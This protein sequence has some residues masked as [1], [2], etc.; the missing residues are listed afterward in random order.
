MNKLTTI[1]G[2]LAL[3]LAVVI[4]AVLL[5]RPEVRQEK[6]LGQ[7]PSGLPAPN[8][9]ATS[10][11]YEVGKVFVQI[12]STSSPERNCHSRV[13]TTVD[14]AYIGFSESSTSTLAES[15]GHIQAASTTETYDSG[16]YGCG[17]WYVKTAGTASN[18]IAI[19]EF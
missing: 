8:N 16:I 9:Y 13:I 18:T 3:I 11:I 15:F 17:V 12:T 6:P 10:S 2:G 5:N 1:L 14:A 4:L 19:T 7:A